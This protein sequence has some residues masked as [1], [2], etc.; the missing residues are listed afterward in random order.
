MSRNKKPLAREIMTD[1]VPVASLTDKI[2]AVTTQL[3]ENI[4]RLE[5][6]TYIY[7]VDARQRLVNVLSTKDL[8]R[9]PAEKPLSEILPKRPLFSVKPDDSQE[10]VAFLAVR[11]K[12]HHLPVVDSNNRLLGAILPDAL[13]T[14]L[15]REG[16]EDMLRLAGVHP[17]QATYDDIFK[18]SVGRSLW[19]R[20]PWLLLG[21]IG[22]ILAAELIAGFTVTLEE[23]LILAAFIPLIV[24]MSDAVGTQME[25]FAVRDFAVHQKLNYAK[26]FWRQYSIVL[27][28]ALLIS[29][30][31][32][33]VSLIL[34][35]DLI[36]TTVLALALFI[37]IN[38]SVLTGLLIPFIFRKMELDPANASGPIATILQD[39]ISITIYFTIATWLLR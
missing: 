2:G 19:H 6:I 21:L 33:A 5:S 18:I 30:A 37:A 3:Q 36:V 20:L 7:V 29:A 24:Y 27:L 4:G 38:A 13:L 8:Y 17:V 31:L 26:Y 15:E 12:L 28:I 39:V 35:Q 34:Y 16:R 25:V 22:G 14:T 1:R 23:N 10:A 11:N 32:F 9:H